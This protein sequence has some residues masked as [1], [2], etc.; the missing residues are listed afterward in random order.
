[1]K[2]PSLWGLVEMRARS[3]STGDWTAEA[4]LDGEHSFITAC[5]SSPA[6]EGRPNVFAGVFVHLSDSKD[7]HEPLDT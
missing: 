3:C 5:S 7:F 6:A 4:L 2:R 1:M